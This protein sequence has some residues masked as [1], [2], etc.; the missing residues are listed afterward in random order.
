MFKMFDLRQTLFIGFQQIHWWK[1]QNQKVDDKQFST[2]R[3]G[4]RFGR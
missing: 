3:Q 2:E 1:K 4:R